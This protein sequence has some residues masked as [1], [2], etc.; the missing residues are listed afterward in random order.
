[1]ADSSVTRRGLMQGTAV[2]GVAA[3]VASA[4]NAQT[5]ATT[6]VEAVWL[7]GTPP[8][9]HEGQCWGVPWPRGAAP[10]CCAS[11]SR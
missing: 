7:D 4:A 2:V 1:M 8:A 5:N 3:A 6:G 11:A 9:S 10:A